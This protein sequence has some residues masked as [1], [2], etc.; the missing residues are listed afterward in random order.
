MY[1]LMYQFA[2]YI[3]NIATYVIECVMYLCICPILLFVSCA[4]NV[5]TNTVVLYVNIYVCSPGMNSESEMDDKV[6]ECCTDADI[7]VYVANG[8]T[9]FETTVSLFNVHYKQCKYSIVCYV[10]TPLAIHILQQVH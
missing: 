7:F 1:V 3:N 5:Y 6:I 9:T 10:L 4:S 8:T 2:H